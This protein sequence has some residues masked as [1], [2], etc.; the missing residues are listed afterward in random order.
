MTELFE[1]DRTVITKHIN[2][3][4]REEELIENRNEQNLH[5]AHSDKPDKTYSLD[6]VISV[7][8]R[9]KSL[10][11]TRFRQWATKILIKLSISGV[12]VNP[13][14]ILLKDWNFLLISSFCSPLQIQDQIA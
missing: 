7:G 11:G 13:S 2:N 4:F 10:E 9:V 1:R 8:Y 3:I 12:W 14:Q 6:V 5:F